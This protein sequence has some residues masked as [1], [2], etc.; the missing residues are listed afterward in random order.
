M[1]SGQVV[2]TSINA[3]SNS[4][5]QAS[6]YLDDQTTETPGFNHL[7]LFKLYHRNCKT[8]VGLNLVLA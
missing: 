4:R 1:T 6:S 2:E 8:M 5:S 7:K 3:T